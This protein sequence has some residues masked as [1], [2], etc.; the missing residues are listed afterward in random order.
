MS[1]TLFPRNV[2]TSYQ[3]CEV[4]ACMPKWS[5]HV[6]SSVVTSELDGFTCPLHVERIEY[7]LQQCSAKLVE[8]ARCAVAK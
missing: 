8:C 1:G 7:Y 6:L 4:H 2:S 3:L 5:V